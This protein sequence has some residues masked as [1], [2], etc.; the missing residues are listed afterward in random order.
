[1]ERKGFFRID[2]AYGGS[3]D[4]PA[5]LFGIPDGRAKSLNAAAAATAPVASKKK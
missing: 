3:K 5:I 4:K 2:R 1:L